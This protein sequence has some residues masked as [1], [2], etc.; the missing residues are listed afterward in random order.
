MLSAIGR[1]FV[2]GISVLLAFAASAFVVFRIGVE[3]MSRAQHAGDE[4]VLTVFD[5]AVRFIMAGPAL[6]AMA[7]IP[8]LLALGV[9]I[10]GEVVRIRHALYY[11]AG[12]GVAMSAIPLLLKGS[13]LHWQVFA[14]A[15]FVGGAVY[16]GLAGRRA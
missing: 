10:V 14:T 7:A 9:V 16:W 12:G 13:V 8:L 5:W 1:I 3:W 4:P 2:V 11:I 15:G 6:Q